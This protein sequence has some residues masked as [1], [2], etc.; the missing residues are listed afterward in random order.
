[1]LAAVRKK[2]LTKV[3]AFVSVLKEEIYGGAGLKR[4]LKVSVADKVV[5]VWYEK[6]AK[7]NKICM[8]ASPQ[9]HFCFLR[10]RSKLQ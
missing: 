2:S 4:S 10:K 5:I 7:V 8:K 3:S 6:M 1:M 9:L